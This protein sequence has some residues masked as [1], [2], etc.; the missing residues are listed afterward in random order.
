MKN[1]INGALSAA[2]IGAAL[3]SSLVGAG[4]AHA[5]P[6]PDQN[7][8][9]TQ[10]LVF[11]TDDNK[12]ATFRGSFTFEKFTTYEAAYAVATTFRTPAVGQWGTMQYSPFT[13]LSCLGGYVDWIGQTGCTTGNQN[14]YRI[15]QDGTLESWSNK[16]VNGITRPS[17]ADLARLGTSN[18]WKLVLPATAPTV[19]VPEAKAGQTVSATVSFPQRVYG[20]LVFT[21]PEHTTIV[22]VDYRSCDVSDDGKT[23]T[24]GVDSDYWT[25]DRVVTLKVDSD[26]RTDASIPW[27][28]NL[29]GGSMKVVK[30]GSADITSTLTAK[31]VRGGWA[32][33]KPTM[34]PGTTGTSTV[35]F[36]NTHTGP[37]T[38]TAPA[39]TT[40]TGI[41]GGTEK[42]TISADGTTATA[43]SGTWT[44]TRTLSLRASATA[45]AGEKVGGSV[46]SGTGL[47][48]ITVPL[49]ANVAETKSTVLGAYALEAK[50]TTGAHFAPGADGTVSFTSRPS[51]GPDGIDIVPGE[52][53]SWTTTL[54]KG[55]EI[56]GNTC[57]DVYTGYTA[58][59]DFG[60]TAPDG[61]RTVVY[62]VTRDAD[63]PAVTNAFQ[64]V[65]TTTYD[66]RAT[67]DLAADAKVVTTFTPTGGHTSDSP[68]TET[69]VPVA[70]GP[71]V[72]VTN[73][74]DPADGYTPGTAFTFTGTATA[75]KT[76]TVQNVFG[77]VLGQNV[78]V[79]ADGTWSWTRANMGTSNW[80]LEFVQDKGTANE[81]KA[82]VYNFKPNA[83][84]APVVTV[85]NPA[86]PADG[87]TPGT[88]FTFTG[89][90][91]AGK[92]ITVQNVFGTVL[93]QNVP[94]QADGTW[95]WT[96]ANMGT[97]N[98]MLEFIQ[99]KGTA[100]EHKATVYNFKPNATPAPVVTVTNPVNP[101]D[102]YPAQTSFTFTGT[103]TAGKT[104]T[105]QN[106]FGT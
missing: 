34:R 5:A 63:Q 68:R 100:N 48:S 7:R 55:L 99:D 87:Y 80:M 93:G 58:T 11:K 43:P 81:H 51:R 106:V 31:V 54:P 4:A 19:S 103:A 41:T 75:G 26:V 20:K 97:S 44:G 102:G 62:T 65:H 101:A 98:W 72:T 92:T 76:I 49:D 95:S 16:K 84:P 83:A 85:T 77:T 46:T 13:T 27:G 74:A 45:E 69:T 15:N 53:M 37:M 12:F 36:D 24:C 10:K 79:A 94:V 6:Q 32:V 60:A 47:N 8:V 42:W 78:P 33:S 2:A 17:S 35:A 59:C 73:P 105:V 22:G 23:A 14:Q 91:T 86:N 25:A 70:Q 9:I 90:A 104:I 89:T 21:A 88:A 38:V 64:H 52:S 61:T 40:L 82:T 18:P 66:V 50:P 3:A 29:P 28:S 39:D 67:A 71:V 57:S 30:S 1:I 56:R 96:R